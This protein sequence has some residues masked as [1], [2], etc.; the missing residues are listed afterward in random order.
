MQKLG[1]E[2]TKYWNADQKS[3]KAVDA[4]PTWQLTSGIQFVKK[5]LTYVGPANSYFTFFAL[6]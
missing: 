3:S 5:S 2:L 6:D 4:K 1:L